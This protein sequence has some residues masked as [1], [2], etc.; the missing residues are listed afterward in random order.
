MARPP[1]IE[2]A[3]CRCGESIWM[4]AATHQTYKRSS[5]TFFCV[6]GH[7]QHFPQGKSEAE[8]LQA[9]LD[10]ERRARQLAEQR[11]AAAKDDALEARAAADKQRRRANGYKGHATKLAK[12]AKAGV[13]P[14]C[15][16]HFIQLARH[17]ATQHPTFAPI[18]L[19][20]APAGEMLQ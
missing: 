9:E 1:Y 10:N 2:L 8:K 6:H 13:C 18:D 3:C 16:R 17:M 7:Q 11:I 4:T 12:R 19:D 15:N 14:C 20:G 5:Q